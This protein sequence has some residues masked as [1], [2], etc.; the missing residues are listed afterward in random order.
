M[1]SDDD[2]LPKTGQKWVRNGQLAK[3]F[4]IST[5]CLWR[6]KHNPALNCPIAYEVNGIEWND[7]NAWDEWLLSRA[8][9]RVD[10]ASRQRAVWLNKGKARARATKQRAVKVGA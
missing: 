2:K 1:S 4:S 6:W 8:V 5:M 10:L 3:H 9:Q 7:Q